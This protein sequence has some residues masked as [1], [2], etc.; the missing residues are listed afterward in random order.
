[1]R[2]CYAVALLVL[3]VIACDLGGATHVDDSQPPDTADPAGDTG[4]TA[5]GDE[6]G[7][8]G[9]PI[10]PFERDDDGDTWSENQG[11][12]RDDDPHVHP[13]ASDTCDGVDT[14]CDG[15][16]D[17]DAASADSWEP[18]D[19]AWPDLGSLDDADTL[20]AVGWLHNE[21]DVDRFSVRI[22]D[23]WY[24][25]FHL[26]VAVSGIP[27]DAN[28]LLTVGRFGDAGTLEDVQKVYGPTSLEVEVEGTTFV[29]DGGTW[30]VQI[31]SLGGADCSRSWLLAVSR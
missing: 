9:E 4:D 23:D 11:D 27:D 17:E 2:P 1:M 5:G 22:T 19:E 25:D 30:G 8:T 20:S 21:D 24:D 14:D 15:T 6:T 31:E 3:P 16:V 18:N 10:D 13:E 29:D 26:A 12:C 28:F 7:D